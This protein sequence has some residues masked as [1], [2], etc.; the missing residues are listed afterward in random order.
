MAVA[1]GPPQRI[2]PLTVKICKARSQ[3]LVLCCESCAALLLPRHPRTA[4]VQATRATPVPAQ[5][6]PREPGTARVQETGA[7][8]V[9]AQLAPR[10]PQRP[11]SRV[12]QLASIQADDINQRQ[13]HTP[14]SGPARST[15]DSIISCEN[16]PWLGRQPPYTW[17]GGSHRPRR[18]YSPASCPT[19]AY[20]R[21]Q[22]W[23][24]PVC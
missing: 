17:P 16:A 24:P 11:R 4:P 23:Q 12:T 1:G 8:P 13:C 7:T 18:S 9:P 10:E 22:A 19:V 2:V 15:H 14:V 3:T 6:A 21:R 20:R 5:L